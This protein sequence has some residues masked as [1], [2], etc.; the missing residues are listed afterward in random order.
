ML[1]RSLSG[2]SSYLGFNQNTQNSFNTNN[3]AKEK[4]QITIHTSMTHHL[5]LR[6]LFKKQSSLDDRRIQQ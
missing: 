6:L 1:E 3:L 4:P 2:E 5:A